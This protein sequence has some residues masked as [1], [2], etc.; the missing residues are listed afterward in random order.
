MNC[1]IE[2]ILNKSKEMEQ[3]CQDNNVMGHIES[4]RKLPLYIIIYMVV[5]KEVDYN[6]SMYMCQ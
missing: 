3:L 1:A 4:L 2:L 6:N 5:V